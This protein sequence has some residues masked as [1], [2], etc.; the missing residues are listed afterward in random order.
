MISGSPVE[1]LEAIKLKSEQTFSRQP[2][3]FLYAG[4]IWCALSISV[5]GQLYASQSPRG[6]L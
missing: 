3:T 2:F 5:T 1:D 6:H 4:K